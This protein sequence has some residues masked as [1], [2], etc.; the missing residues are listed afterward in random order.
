MGT[1]YPVVLYTIYLYA[2]I[3]SVEFPDGDFHI[4]RGAWYIAF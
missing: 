2:M 3:E 4:L 1:T